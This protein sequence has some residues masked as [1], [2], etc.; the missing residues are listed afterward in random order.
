MQRWFLWFAAAVGLAFLAGGLFV[1]RAVVSEG[2]MRRELAALSAIEVNA[3]R[4]W[5]AR[6]GFKR[7]LG[8]GDAGADVALLQKTL[9]AK[10]LLASKDAT[11]FYGSLTKKGVQAF[12]REAALIP[13]GMVDD[14]TRSRLNGMYFGMV[15]PRPGLAYADLSGASVGKDNRMPYDYAPVDL[16]DI[17]NKNIW[18]NG[19][20][21]LG[22]ETAGALGRMVAVAAQ[23][24]VRIGVTSG[25]RTADIQKVLYD[26]WHA[27]KGDV[28]D[29]EISPPAASEHQLGTAVDLTGASVGYEGTPLDFERRPEGRWL[30]V[31]AREYGF[32]QSFPA[33]REAVTGYVH[34]PWHW[35]H[36]GKEAAT[37]I[38]RGNVGTAEYL[39]AHAG[40]VPRLRGIPAGLALTAAAAFVVYV[41]VAER[42]MPITLLHKDPDSARPIASVSKLLTA[43]V[44]E[45]AFSPGTLIPV[46]SAAAGEAVKEGQ[47][48]LVAG[49]AFSLEDIL[50]LLLI[51]SSNPA[52][53][54]LADAYG[55]DRFMELMR[56]EA[57][58]LG[59][60]TLS[61]A[62]PTG[63]D[64]MGGSPNAVSVRDLAVLV[65]EVLDNH[66]AL[67]AILGTAETT[68]RSTAGSAY[69]VR[70]TNNLLASRVWPEGIIGGKTGETPK[71]K[72]ALAFAAMSPVGE[73]YIAIV[74]LESD[75]RFGEADEVLQWIRGSYDWQ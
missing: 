6:F 46:S 29:G 74:I 50:A 18:T 15:C 53:R 25:F 13:T 41:P 19:I 47:S 48:R 26:Y 27:V 55:F 1:H 9:I 64:P 49:D 72:Q 33:G 42:G 60:T 37:A 16:V 56:D 7:D 51:E 32:A 21:C 5:R 38:A 58:R 23:E 71:A 14:A 39:A 62:N 61:V 57:A 66:P 68:V 40:S 65:R 69:R 10:K 44:A 22:A 31:H 17:S 3:A 12:Q 75:D 11:G 63:L 73:G 67:R 45:K 24:G 34:E 4:E 35:R 59:L 36:V 54:A 30:A 43:L 70:T 8:T 2:M 52:A 28:A 20:V